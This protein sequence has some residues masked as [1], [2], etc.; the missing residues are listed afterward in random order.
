MKGCIIK[1]D[2]T[3]LIEVLDCINDFGKYN[4]LITNI[5]CYSLD[6]E[7]SGNLDDEYCWIQ[8]KELLRLLEKEDF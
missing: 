6:E 4:C 7:M 1:N 8:G 2:E 3:S 5:E